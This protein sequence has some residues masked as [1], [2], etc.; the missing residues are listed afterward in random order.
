MKEKFVDTREDQSE[1][2]TPEKKIFGAASGLV[3]SYGDMHTSFFPPEESKEFQ[4]DLSGEFSGIGVEISNRKGLLVVV[5]PLVG[6]PGY[7]AGLK[8]KDVIIEID[9][10]NSIGMPS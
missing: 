6:T 3:D 1:K 2:I 5:A 10:K 8:S 4:D 7:K 9:G